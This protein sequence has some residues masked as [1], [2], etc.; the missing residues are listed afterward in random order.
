MHPVSHP[1]LLLGLGATGHEILRQIKRSASGP[2]AL[3]AAVEV[4]VS[5]VEEQLA[6]ALV[7]LL[8]AGSHAR[9]RTEP[10]LDIVVVAASHE[11]GAGGLARLCGQVVSAI[12]E[13]YSTLFP[14]DRPPEQRAAGL[15]LVLAAPPLGHAGE[16][17]RTF[18]AL[19]ELERWWGAAPGHRLLSRVWLLSEQTLA[20]TLAIEDIHR[21]CAGFIEALLGSGLRDAEPIRARMDHH[22]GG[23]G[24][25]GFA[26]LAALDVAE[27]KLHRYAALRAAHDGLSVLVARVERPASE[28]LAALAGLSTPDQETW[29]TALTEG[30]PA[31]ELRRRA[32]RL[33]GGAEHTPVEVRVRPLDDA[34][35]VRGTHGSLLAPALTPRPVGDADR[36]ELETVL[37]GLD[38]AEAQALTTL[39]GDARRIL[40][41]ALSPAT[42]LRRLPEV[43]LGL[44]RLSAALSDAQARDLTPPEAPATPPPE[45]HLA[46]VEAAIEALP[47]RRDRGLA[48][49]AVGLS[50]GAAAQL[51]V[52]AGQLTAVSTAA[53]STLTAAQVTAGQ[54]GAA[55]G[56]GLLPWVVAVVCGVVAGVL[57]VSFAGARAARPVRLALEHRREALAALR[58][59]GGA[60]PHA[61]EAETQLWLRRRRLRR[62]ASLAIE[63]LLARLSAVRRILLE[64]R[65]HQASAIAAMGLDPSAD[66]D[67]APLFARGGPLSRPLISPAVLA[68]W[69]LRCRAVVDT[70]LWADRLLE[71]CWPAG[72]V[73][74]DAPCA[75]EPA[76]AEACRHQ[77]A[78]LRE[79]SLFEDPDAVREARDTARAF[80]S[81]LST[82]LAPACQ[83]RDAHG[84]PVRGMRGGEVFTVGSL[85]GRDTLAEAMARSPVDVQAL[86]SEERG[87]R[88]LLVRTWEGFRVADLARGVGLSPADG[89]RA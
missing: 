69:V 20:G 16:A 15:H 71:A 9:E 43:E 57:F 83:P 26:A 36:A 31:Q 10:R 73:M 28:P 67:L 70:D 47:T 46:Q 87:A 52:T 17:A 55:S 68:R 27:A 3:M 8:R 6:A 56:A 38:V 29:L 63:A 76:L 77:I 18:A 84:D 19:G 82:A 11:G 64:M 39:L 49:A 41:D 86:W 12:G 13:H 42:G 75:D 51:L 37:R 72:G 79:R 5:G 50:V 60:G 85:T 35:A 54:A 44:R 89:E 21:S 7:P 88:L 65:D 81:K 58:V 66:A 25:F 33:A 40:D 80:V 23:E 53:K 78:P 32:W 61:R 24:L 22:A 48:A 1:T 62:G 74:E 2:D 34:A 4:P 59:A 45:P 14:A 30:A